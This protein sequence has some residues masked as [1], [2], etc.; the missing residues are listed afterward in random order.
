MQGADKPMLMLAGKPLIRHVIDRAAPQVDVL[1][2]NANDDAERFAALGH[3]VI[4]DAVADYPG[5]VAG[6]AAALEWTRR[7]RP[8]ADWLVSFPCDCPLLP[9]DLV[10]RLVSAAEQA[11]VP[12]AVAR[13]NGRIHP[14][15]AAWSADLPVNAEVLERPEMRKVEH[16]IGL[17]PFVPV[18]FDSGGA[19]PFFNINT[20]EDLSAAEVLIRD[21]ERLDA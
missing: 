18:P 11:D 12:V 21:M 10:E 5:P 19:G 2:I 8:D 17:H 4:R 6:I 16:I 1:L 7:N 20:P 3:P 9:L 15:F 14:V 13:D